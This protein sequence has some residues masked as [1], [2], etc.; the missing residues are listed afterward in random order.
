MNQKTAIL[1]VVAFA[2]CGLCCLGIVGTGAVVMLGR[3]RQPD[4]QPVKIPPGGLKVKYLN[5]DA[6]HWARLLMDADEELSRQA[7]V[8]MR[9]IGD[10]S[11]PFAIEAA[12]TSP[13]PHVKVHAFQACSVAQHKAYLKYWIPI[14]KAALKDP[15]RAPRGMATER[16]YETQCAECYPDLLAASQVETDGP[17]RADMIHRLKLLG[18]K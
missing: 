5:R 3:D 13:L 6:E 7:A 9:N 2:L 16:I 15:D 1:C 17:I 11:I 18:V 12:R 4:P 14:Y 10:E 8:A